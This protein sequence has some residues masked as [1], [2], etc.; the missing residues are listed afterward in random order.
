ME[1]EGE[2]EEDLGDDEKS[3]SQLPGDDVQPGSLLVR[4]RLTNPGTDAA[5]RLCVLQAILGCVEEVQQVVKLDLQLAVL[6]ESELPRVVDL[7]LALR[8]AGQEVVGGRVGGVREGRE[9]LSGV[10][11][12]DAVLGPG[13]PHGGGRAAG[14]DTDRVETLQARVWSTDQG[15]GQTWGQTKTGVQAVV[16]VNGGVSGE[17][18]CPVL[19]QYQET[20]LAVLPSLQSPEHL[21]LLTP[22]QRGSAHHKCLRHVAAGLRR[23]NLGRKS[24]PNLQIFMMALSCVAALTVS[25]EKLTRG[26]TLGDLHSGPGEGGQQGDDQQGHRPVVHHNQ[27]ETWEQRPSQLQSCQHQQSYQSHRDHINQLRTSVAS[28]ISVRCECSTFLWPD[29]DDSF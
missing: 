19:V 11:R 15:G 10:L 29:L 25:Q 16:W 1:D 7:D 22:R 28:L 24:P 12:V 21:S 3:W 5:V 2:E 27:S 9:E 20:V 18:E 13:V 14:G 26:T 23:E 8:E 6:S 4:A 17:E